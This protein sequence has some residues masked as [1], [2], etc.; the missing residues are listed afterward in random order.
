MVGSFPHDSHFPVGQS[1]FQPMV[2]CKGFQFHTQG[3]QALGWENFFFSR[4]GLIPYLAL[5]PPIDN[6][7]VFLRFLLIPSRSSSDGFV[8]EDEDLPLSDSLAL[9]WDG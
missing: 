2:C 9:S 6:L 3:Q 1:C 7:R 5:S 8:A 4:P